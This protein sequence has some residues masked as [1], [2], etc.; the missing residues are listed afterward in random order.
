MVPMIQMPDGTMVPAPP[1]GPPPGA[2]AARAS[3]LSSGDPLLLSA[4]HV[5]S[6]F[7]P[8]L[9]IISEL[10]SGDPL[11]L[12]DFYFTRTLPHGSGVGMVPMIKMPDGSLAPAP[13]GPGGPGGPPGGAPPGM[14]PMVRQP[15]GSLLP[16]DPS[17]VPA[18]REENA[19]GKNEISA[20]SHSSE[21][22]FPIHFA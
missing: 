13:G 20:T 1:G 21:M 16:L 11:R 6:H 22:C 5:T 4:L 15:D 18:Q 17:K 19:M 9:W 8:R 10:S 14:V 12:S 2:L 3:E 7:A